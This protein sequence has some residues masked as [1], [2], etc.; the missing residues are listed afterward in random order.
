ML[1]VTTCTASYVP[2]GG[3]KDGAAT[4]EPGTVT[5]SVCSLSCQMRWSNTTYMYWSALG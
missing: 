4:T 5:E 3:V 1:M 2:D